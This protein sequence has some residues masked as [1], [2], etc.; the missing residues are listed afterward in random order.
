MMLY[1]VYDGPRKP[2]ACYLFAGVLEAYPKCAK[3]SLAYFKVDVASNTDRA[4]EPSRILQRRT[5]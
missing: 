3:R 5:R 2:S 4:S 1:V